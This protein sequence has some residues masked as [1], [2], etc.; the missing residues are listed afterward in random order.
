M[1]CRVFNRG[2]E[3]FILARLRKIA[4]AAGIRYITA[5]F[6]PTAKN[7]YLKRVLPALDLRR[8]ASSTG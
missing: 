4:L 1:S 6:R 8:R 3:A 7:D 2:L 5:L